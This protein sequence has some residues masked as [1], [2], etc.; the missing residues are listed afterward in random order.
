MMRYNFF[1]YVL[2]KK[3]M[4]CFKVGISEALSSRIRNLVN[5]GPFDDNNSILI[6][7]NTKSKMRI[8]E[9]DIKDT[10]RKYNFQIKKLKYSNGETEWYHIDCLYDVKQYMKNK[11]K[12]AIS[13]NIKI[14]TKEV[15]DSKINTLM[16]QTRDKQT[17]YN[18]QI[19]KA[20]KQYH[21][22]LQNFNE[23]TK[24]IDK[25]IPLEI[26][27][28][29]SLKFP[30][31]YRY[32]I[33]CKKNGH[34]SLLLDNPKITI[35][36]EKSFCTMFVCEASQE[37]DEYICYKINLSNKEINK[38]WMSRDFII[39]LNDYFYNR[40]YKKEIHRELSYLL[41]FEID[42]LNTKVSYTGNRMIDE[43]IFDINGNL[44]RLL[45]H[46]MNQEFLEIIFADLDNYLTRNK[47]LEHYLFIV[48]SV[49]LMQKA[50]TNR[51]DIY[52]NPSLSFSQN[53]FNNFLSNYFYAS[54][55]EIGKRCQIVE[56]YDLFT[57]D[58]M[59]KT[60]E[61]FTVQ[62]DKNFIE[63]YFAHKK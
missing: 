47:D 21:T 49:L 5:F 60:N 19:K 32:I 20:L 1:L 61:N 13:G 41:D 4:S 39:E 63:K 48:F 53:E 57:L 38:N 23:F 58:N 56:K 27:G 18:K 40:G 62:I 15:W 42:Y 34:E 52:T 33:L 50:Y 10:F 8:I 51:E 9:K 37:N 54:F 59:L 44:D 16:T 25:L 36:N 29:K 28:I 26:V 45:P 2:V 22:K 30:N 31:G 7:S 55:C 3:D 6:P 46:N 11:L 35:T 43:Y 14:I 17:L 24:L 12:H